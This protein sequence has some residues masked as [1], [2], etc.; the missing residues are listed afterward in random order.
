MPRGAPR[1]AEP[2]LLF[3]PPLKLQAE[4]THELGAQH[5]L[6]ASTC[7]T[8]AG[9]GL[10]KRRPK[11]IRGQQ[12]FSALSSMH[13]VNLCGKKQS[14]ANSRSGEA[15]LGFEETEKF[16]IPQPLPVEPQEFQGPHRLAHHSRTSILSAVT[17]KENTECR[18]KGH[19]DWGCRARKDC[20]SPK[21]TCGNEMQDR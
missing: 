7:W 20:F 11:Q 3:S 19:L 17:K 12:G 15:V 16:P 8:N 1:A 10:P 18:S 14:R 9:A 13:R 5:R 4:G 2:V 21:L 6:S